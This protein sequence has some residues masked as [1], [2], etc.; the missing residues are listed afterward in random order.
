MAK[1][2]KYEQPVFLKKDDYEEGETIVEGTYLGTFETQYGVAHKFS[3]DEGETVAMSSKVLNS[4]IES[5]GI[6]EGQ[7]IKLVSLGFKKGKNGFSFFDFDMFFGAIPKG[8]KPKAS[9]APVEDDEDDEDEEIITPPPKAKMNGKGTG[10]TPPPRSHK[11]KAPV[12][13]DDADL[14]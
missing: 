6:V 13:E 1:Y 7:E 5:A 11:K 3:N 2:E 10:K 14:F 8:A 12:V 9:V 4:K